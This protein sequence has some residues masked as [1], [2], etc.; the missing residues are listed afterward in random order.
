MEPSKSETTDAVRVMQHKI[1][2]C[3]IDAEQADGRST[4][5]AVVTGTA[6]RGWECN[7]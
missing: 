1:T 4:A 6:E 2:G 3:E 5:D 7:R